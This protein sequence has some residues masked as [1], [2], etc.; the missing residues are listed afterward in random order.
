M[1]TSLKI[2]SVATVLFLA[3]GAVVFVYANSQN[4]LNTTA[5]EQ[6]Q[7]SMQN[8][9]ALFESDN[10]TA[11]GHMD[12][13]GQMRGDDFPWTGSFLENA[14][15]STVQGTV[16]SEVKGMLIMNTDTGQI[17]VMLPKEWTLDNEVVGR[18]TLFN[19]TFASP[20]QSVTIKVL[21]STVFSNANF[22]VNTMMGHEAI[23]ATG[24][25]AYAVLPFNIQ[26]SS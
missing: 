10:C 20:G 17:R 19:G 24:T 4:N 18:V 23:N 21:E 3:L 7:I 12:H 26:P 14:T 2:A 15:L 25:H 13:R 6:Q 22:S 11:H 8:M 9:Q 5:S 16:V 1:R